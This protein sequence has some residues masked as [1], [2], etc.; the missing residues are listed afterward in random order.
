MVIVMMPT[1]PTSTERERLDEASRSLLGVFVGI[2]ATL[3][4]AGATKTMMGN[5]AIAR[6]AW[7]NELHDRQQDSNVSSV[8]AYNRHHDTLVVARRCCSFARVVFVAVVVVVVVVVLAAVGDDGD[9][10]DQQTHQP[11][12]VVSHSR[13]Y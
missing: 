11:G 2:V 5:C 1:P 6:V 7:W 9:D 8:A 12:T 3:L 13:K 10:D 4:L